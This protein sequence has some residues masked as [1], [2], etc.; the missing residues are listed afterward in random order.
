MKLLVADITLIENGLY[1][2]QFCFLLV[3]VVLCVCVSL[4]LSY[5]G[6]ESVIEMCELWHFGGMQISTQVCNE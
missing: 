2:S 6:C 5:L 4:S 1:I 3:F